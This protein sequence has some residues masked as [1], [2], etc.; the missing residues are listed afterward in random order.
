[1]GDELFRDR[2]TGAFVA[3][4]PTTRIVTGALG[5]PSSNARIG[6]PFTEVPS[7]SRRSTS[8][9]A[10]AGAIGEHNAPRDAAARTIDRDRDALPDPNMS[11][12]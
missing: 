7:S 5:S 12:V 8:G 11:R 9:S 4:D 2:D 3:M 1:M 6:R 10:F